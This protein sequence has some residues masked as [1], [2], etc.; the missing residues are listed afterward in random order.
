MS[1]FFRLRCTLALDQRRAYNRPTESVQCRR[2][3]KM[4][5][6]FDP[7]YKWLAIRERS[8]NHILCLLVGWR[9]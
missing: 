1:I 4:A 5:D 8:A 9:F 7:Y 2:G 3:L 6:P